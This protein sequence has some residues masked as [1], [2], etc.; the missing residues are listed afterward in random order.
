MNLKI[1]TGV[2]TA[3]VTG[4]VLVP[5]LYGAY[6]NSGY[7]I[8]GVAAAIA[9]V[10]CYAISR[11][12]DIRHEKFQKMV[13]ETHS[14]LQSTIKLQAEHQMQFVSN[15]EQVQNSLLQGM[16][17]MR[18]FQEH[19]LL[20][21]QHA[22]NGMTAIAADQQKQADRIAMQLESFT[23]RVESLFGNL[24]KEE[25]ESIRNVRTMIGENLTALKDSTNKAERNQT[26]YLSKLEQV[27]NTAG[28]QLSA[29]QKSSSLQAKQQMSELK[30]AIEDVLEDTREA[31]EDIL[32]SQR[33][34]VRDILAEIQSHQ[35]SLLSEVSS[36]S[37]SQQAN[38]ELLQRLQKEILDLNKQDMELISKLMLQEVL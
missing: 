32:K 12:S 38:L 31:L 26:D 35:T 17:G 16:E 9:G 33:R 10:I 30:V 15:A 1:V 18:S 8:A 11:A 37:V 23:S 25:F 7:A 5:L 28:E 27:L 21:L 19:T 14:A 34:D 6:G 36:Q 20:Q 13:T 3:I 2:G 24:L 4:S 29:G 22:V